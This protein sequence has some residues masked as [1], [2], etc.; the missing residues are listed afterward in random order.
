[1]IMRC[2][3]ASFREKSPSKICSTTPRAGSRARRPASRQVLNYLLTSNRCGKRKAGTAS[4]DAVCFGWRQVDRT[5][6][7]GN[8]YS[9]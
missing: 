1:L 9:V 6:R 2:S 5:L 7:A 8:A 3:K 4:I